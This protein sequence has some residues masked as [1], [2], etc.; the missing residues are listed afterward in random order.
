MKWIAN[1]D[2]FGH[3]LGDF[4]RKPQGIYKINMYIYL[5]I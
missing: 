4:N 5:Y 2:E 3:K 1:Y